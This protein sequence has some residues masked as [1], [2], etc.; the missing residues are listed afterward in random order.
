MDLTKIIRKL[1]EER[2]KLDKII[3]SLEQLHKS[4]AAVQAEALKRRR[5]RKSM[6]EQARKEVSERMKNYW[7]TRRKQNGAR[8][9]PA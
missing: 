1:Y 9:S 5:G 6:D 8:S 7:A 2:A 3:T 4:A